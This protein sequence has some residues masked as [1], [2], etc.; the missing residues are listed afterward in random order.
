MSELTF[1]FP[2]PDFSQRT[3]L[4]DG[5][6]WIRVQVPWA[7]DHVNCWWLN[8][9]DASLL[10][11][12]GINNGTTRRVW[13]DAIPERVLITHYH[14]DHCGLA[15]WFHERGSSLLSQLDEISTMRRIWDAPTDE[16]VRGFSD[17]F[18]QH[19]IAREKISP[20]AKMGHTY[21]ATVAEFPATPTWQTLNAGDVLTVGSRQ[22]KVL[23]GAGHSLAMLMLFCE[24]DQVLIAADQILPS[25]S[26]NISVLPGTP[27]ANPL[28]SFLDSLEQLLQLP[29]ETL[30]LPSHGLPFVG[31][32]QRVQALKEHHVARLEQLR[33]THRHPVQAADVLTTLFSRPLDAQQLSFALGEAIAHLRYLVSLGE[34]RESVTESELGLQT[35]FVPATG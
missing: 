20:L 35:H 14:P 1:P 3:A 26:P 10:I 4:I 12:T 2:A 7:L 21:R 25:I 30:V 16:Y 6:D 32:H 27:D 22:F 34:W 15:G 11:D 29:E 17:W 9:G 8:D 18:A 31:L 19:G 33:Q 24:D 23:T 13:Q 5:I 28:H